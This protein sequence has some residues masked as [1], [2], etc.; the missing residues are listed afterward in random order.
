MRAGADWKF[1]AGMVVKI[2]PRSSWLK[3]PAEDGLRELVAAEIRMIGLAEQGGL[4]S[5]GGDFR[6]PCREDICEKYV[7]GFCDAADEFGALA[8][9]AC[10]QFVCPYEHTYQHITMNTR[11]AQEEVKSFTGEGLRMDHVTTVA[12]EKR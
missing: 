7:L 11:Q 8:E 5:A 4:R 2:E 10:M 6:L 12:I 3:E 1:K 9:G